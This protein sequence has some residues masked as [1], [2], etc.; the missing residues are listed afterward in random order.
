MGQL[1]VYFCTQ[2]S[3][4]KFIFKFDFHRFTNRLVVKKCLNPTFKL[5]FQY[6]KSSESFYFKI[7]AQENF[8]IIVKI[9]NFNICFLN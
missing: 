9:D 2:I 4:K 8:F 3:S 6:Q 5:N 7:S 1:R